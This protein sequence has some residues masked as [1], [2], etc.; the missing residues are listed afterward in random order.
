MMNAIGLILLEVIREYMTLWNLSFFLT[1]DPSTV[2][3]HDQNSQG[4]FLE[5][6][7]ETKDD[8]TSLMPR[9]LEAAF[10]TWLDLNDL[11]IDILYR[12]IRVMRSS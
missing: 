1:N 9:D 10:R 8:K 4:G 12:V 3:G 11:Q 6:R 5:T 7:N 2:H